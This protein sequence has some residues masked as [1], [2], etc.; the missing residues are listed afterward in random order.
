MQAGVYKFLMRLAVLS[1]LF[2][3]VN[4]LQFIWTP[5]YYG[6]PV[7]EAKHAALTEKK[8]DVNT[9]FFGS[10]RTFRQIDPSQF[11]S[12]LNDYGISSFNCGSPAVSHPEQ[13]FL[14][15]SFLKEGHRGIR[16]AFLE[17]KPINY[18]S[19]V[20]LWTP[21][22]YYWHSTH[23][24]WYV[25]GYLKDSSLPLK[26]K[27][28]YALDYTF[29]LLLKHIHIGYLN[30]PSEESMTTE[31]LLGRKGDGFLTLEDQVALTPDDTSY[32]ERRNAFLSDTTI[33]EGRIRQS[34]VD[35]SAPL[36]RGDMN[37]THLQLL[38]DLI[39]QSE[40]SGIHLFLVVPPMLQE[41]RETRA[42]MESLPSSHVIEL[43][44]VRRHPEFYDV[45]HLF[46]QGH[47]NRK[48]AALYTRKLALAMRERLSGS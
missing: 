3:A 14:Y 2:L 12:L 44:D 11:D 24:L 7:Y 36:R 46:D 18:I 45:S 33:L 43:A 23:W 37:E 16:Y 5:P 17:L 38:K 8:E 25:Y 21:R 22:N 13:Y 32:M 6:N 1:V 15:D 47:L 10:S 27:I 9:V 20:N 34:L 4:Q 39:A 28:G 30:R 19:R 48:G 31:E 35:F 41:Y 29:T 26:N 40:A 42:L